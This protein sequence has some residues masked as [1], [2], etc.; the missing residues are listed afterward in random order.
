MMNAQTM[1]V[2]CSTRSVTPHL[3]Q[4]RT[5]QLIYVAFE[6]L[7]LSAIETGQADGLVGVSFDGTFTWVVPTVSQRTPTGKEHQGLLIGVETGYLLE[8]LD[9]VELT[10]LLQYGGTLLANGPTC[11]GVDAQGRILLQRIVSLRQL[12]S[13]TLAAEIICA[14]HLKRL[15][16]E[17][18][19]SSDRR[20][21]P[22]R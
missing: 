6:Q 1:P 8:N 14:V 17:V 19:Q 13:N 10:Q 2:R 7:Q 3:A 16:V 21:W 4:Q 12:T 9:R 22:I 11:I 20:P 18:P 15:L 5:R